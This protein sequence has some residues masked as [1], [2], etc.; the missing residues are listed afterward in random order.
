[1]ILL[2]AAAAIA[3]S[4]CASGGAQPSILASC[5]RVGVGVG[6]GTDLAYGGWSWDRAWSAAGDDGEGVATVGATLMGRFTPYLQGGL[7]VPVRLG[8][9]RV[10]GQTSTELGLGRG[11]V[12]LELESPAGWPS[13]RA[14]RMGLQLGL[15]NGGV[16]ATT[17]GTLVVQGSLH[18]A[19]EAAPWALWGNLSGATAIA[20]VQSP[21]VEVSLVVDHSLGG[22]LRAGLGAA[23]LAFP[24]A[25]PSYAASVGPTLIWSPNHNDRI[26]LGARAGLPI[27][28]LGQN[29]PSRLVIT[30]DWYRVLSHTKG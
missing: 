23:F 13:V 7:R 21:E 3:G 6:V 26:V 28:G 30:L 17:P 29:A 11:L 14:P 18:A 25:I 24:G 22:R 1:M 8:M 2:L 15:G 20:G 16:A 19:Y 12:W 5:D 4:C 9:D 27:A 10:D